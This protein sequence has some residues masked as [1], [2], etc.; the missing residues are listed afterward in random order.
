MKEAPTRVE[1]IQNWDGD[2]LSLVICHWCIQIVNCDTITNDLM[3]NDLM[4]ND[5][6][7]QYKTPGNY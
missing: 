6:A 3:T 7:K 5:D 1:M 4:T 2:I